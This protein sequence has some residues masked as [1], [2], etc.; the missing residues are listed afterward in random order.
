MKSTTVWLTVLASGLSACKTFGPEAQ[1]ITL[2]E[3]NENGANYRDKIVKV[4]GWATK[5]FEDVRI[6]EL[7]R[8]RFGDEGVVLGVN[9]SQKEPR[10]DGAE[11]RCITGMLVPKGGWE[12]HAR[13]LAGEPY[14]IVI[15]NGSPRAYW[16]IDQMYLWRH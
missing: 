15:S 14:D 2:A 13:K 11:K 5:Q 6:T 1:N 10:T 3:A 4:C 7:P 12:N 9:W 16:E 8:K